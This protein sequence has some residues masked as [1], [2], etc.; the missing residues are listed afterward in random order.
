MAPG[1][2]AEA[3]PE[4]ARILRQIAPMNAPLIL[5]DTE[6]AAQAGAPHLVELAA[7]KVVEGQVVDRFHSLVRPHVPVDPASEAV[8]G[9]G[10]ADLCEARGA[11]EVLPAFTAF[12]GRD[13]LVAHS[14]RSDARVLGF[15]CTRHRLPVPAGRLLDSQA[16]AKRW[17]PGAPRHGLADLAEHLSLATR[18][19]HRAE[20]DTRALYE[21]LAALLGP[22]GGWPNFDPLATPSVARPRPRVR[23]PMA[24]A[25]ARRHSP[26]HEACRAGRA[27]TLGFGER[28]HGTHTP[29]RLVP[30]LLYPHGS[31]AFLE[32]RC[33][34]SGALETHALDT[35]QYV[36]LD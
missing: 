36:A 3:P 2:P 17:L 24:P 31:R 7:W 21:L 11:E 28:S 4:A 14:V 22:R 23:T 6:S 5:F 8:H 9:M 29:R 30:L 25:L 16:L 27:V 35:I 1:P 12:A 18:P 10:S 15:E 34:A 13:W 19:N 20:T 33:P 32:T 26:L